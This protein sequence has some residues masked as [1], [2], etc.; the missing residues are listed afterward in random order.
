MKRH[1]R[2]LTLL[3]VLC[4]ALVA[5]GLPGSAE[6]ETPG[7]G[8]AAAPNASEP[9]AAPAASPDA[10]APA[11]S[12]AATGAS[13]SANSPAVSASPGGTA[14]GTGSQALGPVTATTKAL[15]NARFVLYVDEKTGNLR[16]ADK[17][18]GK[19]WLGAPRLEKTA[20][21]NV[22]KFTDS[23]VHVRYTEGGDITQTY[24]LKEAD[25]KTAV[26]I[27]VDRV[28]VEFRFEK[29][30]VSFA[31]E[32]RLTDTGFEATIPESSLKEEGT[33]RLTSL[34]PLPFF[35]AARETDEGA[36]FLPDGS[37]ALLEF[38][39]EHQAYLKGYSEYIYGADPTFLKQGHTNIDSDWRQALPPKEAVALPVFGIYKNGTGFL[40][41]VTQ[42]ETDAKINGVPAGVRSI[43]LYRAST[44]FLVRK[45]DVI[46]VGN[47]GQ[48]PY[49]QGKPLAGDRTVRYVLL[50][51]E[52]AGYVGMAKAYRSY[53][54]TEQGVKPVVQASVPLSVDILGGLKRDEIIGSTFIRMTTFEQV[55]QMIDA[56]AQAGV[57]ELAL[58]L[59]GWSHDGLYGDQP[60]HFPVD[61]HL[62]GSKEL[63]EL[64]QYASGKG[65]E[66]DLKANYV[67]AYQDS[68]GIRA[69]KDSVR[70]LNREV[71]KNSNY[72]LS[73][74]WNNNNELFYLLKPERTYRKHVA[75]E[76]DD[77]ASLGISGVLFDYVGKL[78]YSDQDEGS[79][80]T[81]R[82]GT[83]AAYLSAL[84]SYRTKLGRTAVEYGF[85]YTL[86]HTD[87]IEGAP[88]D[89]SGFVYTDK[90][91]P[92]YPLVLH[93]LVPYSSSAVNLFDDPV[94]QSLRAVEYGAE[95]RY[96][97]TYEPTSRLQRTIED[98][99][100]SSAFADWL[101][102][103]VKNY[104]SQ[105]E[106][107]EKIKNQ[108]MVG[109]TELQPGLF[110]TTYQNG[111]HV[112]VN[113]NTESVAAE[114]LTVGA[115]SYAVTGG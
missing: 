39:K 1:K 80:G 4:F 106:L 101:E 76:L 100:F 51:G 64:A 24:S 69:S 23:P 26:S 48:I 57:T 45:D 68:D 38:R 56:Y 6:K 98:R 52:D 67:R 107:L 63:K 33:V 7:S 10:S 61:K 14:A 82:K 32:Y 58:S 90:T 95:P 36:M 55:R 109:H 79:A 13:D 44:E 54:T 3:L 96:E 108:Q 91:V 94:T 113:Y 12:P 78:L 83:A 42:G 40:A 11:A 72:Y 66:L 17:T 85:A 29:L 88:L 105:K 71:L 41:I 8:A 46:F 53:L 103:S 111:V 104:R 15:E 89:S 18:T 112:Y 37:G 86:G 2:R 9:A 93:G 43:A 99:L 102:P 5:G 115:Q 77:Y 49:Y 60:D 19:E 16:V 87:R 62:G 47:S 30:K 50:E 74:P 21:P 92:F 65:V 22:K 114:G 25:T 70:G 97:L 73:S 31:M 35:H 110:K 59:D 34:E 84:D 28:R 20:M 27:Q 81:D 75:R